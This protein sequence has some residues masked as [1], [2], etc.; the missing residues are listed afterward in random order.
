MIAS[1]LIF[2]PLTRCIVFALNWLRKVTLNGNCTWSSLAVDKQVSSYWLHWFA[3]LIKS[4]W[5]QVTLKAGRE[6]AQLKVRCPSQQCNKAMLYLHFS[7][8]ADCG[9]AL[10][11]DVTKPA[12]PSSFTHGG[13]YFSDQMQ[14]QAMHTLKQNTCKPNTFLFVTL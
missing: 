2:S 5:M 7:F 3:K 8:V 10:V 11:L 14:L 1:F 6:G 4:K 12:I 9:K 13:F